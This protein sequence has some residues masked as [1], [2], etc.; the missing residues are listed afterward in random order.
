TSMRFFKYSNIV[1]NRQNLASPMSEF[2]GILVIGILLV[3]GGYLVFVDK[4]MEAGF[5]LGYILL[6]YN[7][8]TPAKAISKASYGLK[9]GNASAERVLEILDQHNPIVS[10]PSALHRTHF[11]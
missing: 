3:Y 2:L 9:R 1:L 6:A 4:Q 10:K 8:L 7:I 5:F 11:E